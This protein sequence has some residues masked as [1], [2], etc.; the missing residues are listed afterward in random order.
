VTEIPA[1]VAAASALAA[2]AARYWQ[3]RRHNMTAGQKYSLVVLAGLSTSLLLDVPWVQTTI[4]AATDVPYLSRWLANT[5]AM[6]AVFSAR[7]MIVWA[8]VGPHRLNGTGQMS[9]NA[10]AGAL[11]AGTTALLLLSADE[12]LDPD[13]VTA[14]FRDEELA[15]GQ[16][17]YW[18]YMAAG[19]TN[20]VHLMRRYLRRLD[21]RAPMH[22]SMLVV[23]LAGAMGVLCLVWNASLVITQHVSGHL[24]TG[25]VGVSRSLG[26]AAVCL[27]AA[28]LTLPVWSPWI[29]RRLSL[30]RTR[31]T[32]HKLEPMWKDMTDLVPATAG[33]GM[34]IDDDPEVVLYRKVIEVRDVLLRLMGHVEPEIEQYVVRAE[35]QRGERGLPRPVTRIPACEIALAMENFRRGRRPANSLPDRPTRRVFDDIRDEAEWLVAVHRAMRTDSIVRSVVDELVGGGQA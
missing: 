13:M 5:T 17:L 18:C 23:T 19:T 15:C 14:I 6:L 3:V 11:V 34:K 7:A 30:R 28:G 12:G 32:L 2:A 31:H 24:A 9:W 26:S 8:T 16:A 29:R 10:Y 22:Y 20:F 21:V 25:A 27:I 4:A 35:T 1:V 33:Y